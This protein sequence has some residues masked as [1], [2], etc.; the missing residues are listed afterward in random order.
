ML[1]FKGPVKIIGG[2]SVQTIH[3]SYWP[4]SLNSFREDWVMSVN[5]I[6]DIF[7]GGPFIG[8]NFMERK[9]LQIHVHT[10]DLTVM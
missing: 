2:Q 3:W 8:G 7:F 9:D 5:H 6:T 10:C 4:A 1:Y